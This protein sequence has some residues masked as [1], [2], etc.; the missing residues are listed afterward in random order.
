M[1]ALTASPGCSDEREELYK[2][3]AVQLTNILQGEEVD[4]EEETVENCPGQISLLNVFSSR[5]KLSGFI[6]GLFR[7]LMNC[8][9]RGKS[10]FLPKI[11]E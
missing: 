8:G 5:K 7:P 3:V 6:L 2:S 11:L 1:R 10:S 4:D 9:N